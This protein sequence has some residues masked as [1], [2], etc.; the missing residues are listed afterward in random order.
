MLQT[1]DLKTA[2]LK[3]EDSKYAF[4]TGYIIQW[5][6][7]IL[8][9]LTTLAKFTSCRMYVCITNTWFQPCLAVIQIMLVK[10]QC[11]K[12]SISV[13]TGHFHVGCKTAWHY[14]KNYSDNIGEICRSR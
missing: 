9:F 7:C 14:F 11:I 8:T 2:Y 12:S 1:E 3:S 13:A 4:I 6:G 5:Q 10:L